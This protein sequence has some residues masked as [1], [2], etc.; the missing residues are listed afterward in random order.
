[1]TK[2]AHIIFAHPEEK[3]FNGRLRDLAKET[4][5]NQG[6]EVSIINLYQEKFKAIADKDDF[7][8][9]HQTEYFD[10]QREQLHA[11]RE[12][13]FSEDIQR[14]HLRLKSADLV[15]FQFPLWWYSIPALLKGY[16][17]RVFSF[18]FAYGN[19]GHHLVGKKA[20]I[21]LTTGAPES[22]WHPK[23][24]GHLEG[25][26]H[27]VLKGTLE[28]CGMEVLAPT[29]AYGSKLMRPEERQVYEK[30]FSERIRSIFK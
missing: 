6:V 11:F 8:S 25:H 1:M 16:F 29:I 2:K 20:L 10:L 24:R 9:I 12:A 28:F 23:D 26:L 14:E 27:H 3:S 17:D 7:T 21:S 19:G 22:M 18:G 30:L 13:N 15:I 4:L 5:E